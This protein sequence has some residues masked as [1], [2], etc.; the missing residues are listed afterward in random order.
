M[1]KNQNTP[2]PDDLTDA[3]NTPLPVLL[4]TQRATTNASRGGVQQTVSKN[5][6]RKFR[7]TA[8]PY[9]PGGEDSWGTH[10]QLL[11]FD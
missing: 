6:A 8:N 10:S 1:A 5:L 4:A 9:R 11:G 3:D 7:R 2:F